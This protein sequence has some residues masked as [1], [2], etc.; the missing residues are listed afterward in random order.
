MY[1][2]VP[3]HVAGHRHARVVTQSSKS[4]IRDP[5]M[6]AA[7]NHDV[8][9][10]DVAVHDSFRVSVIERERRLHTEHRNVLK[11]DR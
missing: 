6:H 1:R 5:Q 10:F 4:E 7:I 2:A 11:Q 8:G 9:R 3:Q